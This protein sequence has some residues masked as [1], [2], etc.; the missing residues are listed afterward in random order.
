MT[1]YMAGRISKIKFLVGYTF[2]LNGYKKMPLSKILGTHF[3]KIELFL[4][5]SAVYV[6][7]TNYNTYNFYQV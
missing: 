7:L 4:N 6:P 5:K 1:S 3:T 2:F